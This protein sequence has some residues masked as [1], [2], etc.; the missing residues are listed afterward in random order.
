MPFPWEAEV[1]V[2]LLPKLTECERRIGY[3]FQDKR[4]L[5]TALTHASGADHRLG[6]NERLEFLGDAILGSVVCEALFRRFPNYL[7]GD[8]TKIKSIVVSRRNCCKISQRLEMQDFLLLGKG[9][10]STPELP[11]SLL[12]DVFEALVAAIYLDGGEEPAKN[13]V[14]KHVDPEITLAQTGETG[15]N[16]KSQLQQLAQRQFGTTPTYVLVEEKGPDHSK[17]FSVAAKVAGVCYESAWGKN[18][19]EAEQGAASNALTEIKANAKPATEKEA[20]EE[21]PAT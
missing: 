21:D 17:V 12:A 10:A 3:E 9:M 6:S 18:K 5:R 14:H 1:P 15:D 16:Y 2:E 4:F 8:L 19:K 20:V 11:A 13:F 7:E